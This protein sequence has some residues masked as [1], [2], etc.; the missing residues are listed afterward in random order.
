MHFLSTI[1]L[2]EDPD[3]RAIRFDGLGVQGKSLLNLIFNKP[4]GIIG[5]GVA[6]PLLEPYKYVKP[7]TSQ[8]A[9][10]ER[11][12]SLPTRGVFAEVFLSCCNATEKRDVERTIDPEQ[13]CGARAPEI[14]AS[15]RRA[16]GIALILLRRRW[17]HR[18]SISNAAGCS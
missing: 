2:S 1:W 16:G 14:T 8:P 18:L 3:R 10:A 4:L 12:V 13:S 11:V 6:F 9:L 7:K 5:N 17:L 15:R